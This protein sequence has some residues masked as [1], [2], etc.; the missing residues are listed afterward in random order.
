MRRDLRTLAAAVV[1]LIGM[2]TADPALAQ[3][4][5]GILRVYF[6]DSPASMSIHEETTAA[7][8]GPMMAVFN[9]L[10]LFKQDLPPTSRAVHKRAMIRADA[11]VSA[12]AIS[13]AKRFAQIEFVTDSP[14]EG[15]GFELVWGFPC[16][17]VFFGL[18]PVLCSEREGGVLRPVAY[19]QVPGARARGSRDRNASKACRLAA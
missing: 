12:A 15:H 6:F 2:A 9:N 19:D 10:V 17:V 8:Q 18:L 3:K 5:G 11:L 1:L 4:P 16:Q 7:G 13:S 14:L